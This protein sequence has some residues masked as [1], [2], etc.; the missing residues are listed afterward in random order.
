MSISVDVDM[1]FLSVMNQRFADPFVAVG[2]QAGDS[3]F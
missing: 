3:I 2:T 1:K